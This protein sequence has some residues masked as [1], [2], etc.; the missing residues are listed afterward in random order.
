MD[1]FSI[2]YSGFSVSLVLSNYEYKTFVS[3]QKLFQEIAT[4]DWV[5]LTHSPSLQKKRI[6]AKSSRF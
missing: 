5:W 2:L 1:F 3:K 4:H 6:L